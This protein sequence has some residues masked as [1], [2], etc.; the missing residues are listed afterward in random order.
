MKPNQKRSK[1]YISLIFVA[2]IIYLVVCLH[3]SFNYVDFGYLIV[4]IV[5]FIRF[6]RIKDFG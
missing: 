3:S 5:S 2:V 6:L 4:I 1:Q